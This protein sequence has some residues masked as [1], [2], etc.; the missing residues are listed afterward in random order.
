MRYIFAMLLLLPVAVGADSLEH[1][2]AAGCGS[3]G[4]LF[5]EGTLRVRGGVLRF[6]D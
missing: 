5:S 4:Q 6:C 2:G 3:P 1:G